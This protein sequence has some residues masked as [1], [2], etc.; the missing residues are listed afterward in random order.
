MSVGAVLPIHWS[1]PTTPRE[2]LDELDTT[3]FSRAQQTTSV[4]LPRK[5]DFSR[6]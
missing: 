2:R 3:T 4:W 1:P 6:P 5:R